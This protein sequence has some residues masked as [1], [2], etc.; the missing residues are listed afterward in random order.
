MAET[1]IR[2]TDIIEID[3]TLKGIDQIIKELK[4]LQ[5]VMRDTAKEVVSFQRSQDP[6]TKSGKEGTK[7]ASTQTQKLVRENERLTKSIRDVTKEQTKLKKARKDALT[8]QRRQIQV[9]GAARGSLD[10]NRVALQKLIE[11]YRKAAP[12]A[13]KRMEKG[14]QTLTRTIKTQ[15]AAV[16][17]HERNVGNYT[18]AFNK[19][20]KALLSFGAGM[21]GVTAIMSV[22]TRGI[23]KI[24]GIATEFDQGMANVKAITNASTKEFILLT[25]SAIKLGR[26][27]KFTATQVSEL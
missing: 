10:R 1:P 11:R 8:E 22:M 4:K 13:A 7:Q 20:K 18:G 21:I 25:A 23:R 3:K 17:R 2:H 9:M 15:E 16:G 24:M 19:A 14:I 5:K 26:V 27:T 6:S 12:A